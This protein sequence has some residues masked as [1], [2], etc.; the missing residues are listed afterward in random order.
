M[1]F[2]PLQRQT[3]QCGSIKLAAFYE[4][5]FKMQMLKC[6]MRPLHFSVFAGGRYIA[7]ATP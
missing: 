7:V 6:N 2:K 3:P 4:L 5:T 1:I